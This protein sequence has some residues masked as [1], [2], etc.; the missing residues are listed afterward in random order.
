MMRAEIKRHAASRTTERAAIHRVL[1]QTFPTDAPL[2][3]FAI[4]TDYLVPT[5]SQLLDIHPLVDPTI[6]QRLRSAA[7]FTA[8]A[9]TPTHSHSTIGT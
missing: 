6:A 1:D 7:D 3:L 2:D 4:V 9:P 8:P 5:L